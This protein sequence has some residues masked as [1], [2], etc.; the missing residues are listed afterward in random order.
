MEGTQDQICQS[1]GMPMQKNEDFATNTDGSK[2][3][4]YCHFCY[5]EEDLQ[6]KELQWKRKSTKT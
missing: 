5:K 2:N 4:E 1:C 6:M 3:E